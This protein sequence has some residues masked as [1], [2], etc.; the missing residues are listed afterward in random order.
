N[1]LNTFELT[2]L[3]DDI[4]KIRDIMKK[5]N[6][7]GTLMTG[8]G[9]AVFG[10]FT[11]KDKAEAAETELDSLFPFAKVCSNICKDRNNYY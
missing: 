10:I 4:A 2:K 5:H 9:A 7:T 11:D 6:T 3:P 8:S 1:A